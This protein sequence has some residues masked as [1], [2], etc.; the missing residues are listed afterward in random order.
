MVAGVLAEKQARGGILGGYGACMVVLLAAYYAFPPGR[1]ETWGLLCLGGV[2]GILAGLWRYRP[3]RK[4]PWLLLAA[5]LASFGAGQLSFLV[6]AQ[7]HAVLPFPSFADA[8]YLACYPLAA[9]GL[10]GF[11]SARSPHG[12]RRALI[13]GLTLTVA[14]GLLFWTFLIEPYVHDPSLSL[15]QR[16][17]TVAYP[18]G[19]VLV[20]ALLARLLAPGT[21]RSP[22]V[23]LLAVGGVA[24]MA[25]DCV[26]GWVQLSH[27]FENGGPTDLGWALFYSAWG[28]AA[29]HPTMSSLTRPVRGQQA[30]L[31]RARL[32]V[33]LLAA[34]IAPLVMLT[35][36]RRG[37]FSDVTVTAFFS[38]A[39]YMLVLARLWDSAASNQR[40][41]DRERVLRQAGLALDTA[42]DAPQIG[43]AVKNAAS[44]LLGWHA[45]GDALLGVWEDGRL[46]PVGSRADAPDLGT[47]TEAWPQ[48]T[49]GRRSAL[50]CTSA[51]PGR[52]RDIRPDAEWVLLC[53]LNLDAPGGEQIGL[54]A[55]FG[56][57]RVLADL[58]AT[59]E[60]L[61]HQAALTLQRF[62][63][64]QRGEAYFRDV[65]QDASDA[66][67]IIEDNGA[68]KYAT[69][70]T[71]SIFGAVPGRGSLFWDLV[72]EQDRAE[73]AF[74][75]SRLR[76]TA[77]TRT[78][79]QR[80]TLPD[81]RSVFI[82][83]R[84]S[85]LRANPSVAGLVLTVRDVTEQHELE[86][87]L[88]RRAFHDALTG[89]PNRVLLQD[90]IEQQA[91]AAVRT[92]AIAGVLLVDLDD[93]KIV[94]DTK[95][96]AAGDALLVAIAAR[97]SDHVRGSDTAARLGGDEF[98]VLI[99]NATD[100]LSVEA[101]A[102]RL[103]NAF[104]EPFRLPDG[105]MV[106]T[107]ITVGVA[108]TLDGSDT[109]ELL[110]HAD[111]ALYAAK[112]A[113]KRQWRR[114]QP[115]LS[116]DLD[117]EREL[118]QDLEE[119]AGKSE[120]TLAYQPIA[121]LVSGELTG[122][123]ALLR[124]PH[125]R[126]G[127]LLP[128]QFITLAEETGH[129]VPIG[130]WVLGQA[131]RDLAG[132]RRSGAGS[133]GHSLYVS[134]NVS[135]RQLEDPGFASTVRR[136]LDESGLAPSDLVLELTESAVMRNGDPLL[137]DLAGLRALG[138]RLAI[139]DFGTGYS[140]LSYLRYLPVDLIKI[141]KSF[142][143]GLGSDTRQLAL[144]TGIV[145]LAASLGFQVI[146][147]GIET[148]PQRDL[149]ASM[150]CHFGQGY[151]LARPMLPA[152]AG[153]LIQAGTNRL[154][155][156]S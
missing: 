38:A 84:L 49:P 71:A 113:G 52:A 79:N 139:D 50:A 122:F 146:A 119:A 106:K 56:E 141:D 24:V 101:A 7:V 155:F 108:T 40:A 16:A 129:I 153:E 149:L 148:G 33:L 46:R 105:T 31:S 26:Y 21:D 10:L 60:I 65:V 136:T 116:A 134:V 150:G 12:D 17:V 30:A 74:T 96:H 90:R 137:A 114:Y 86:Q 75:F 3:A 98:A 81:G 143:A 110:R 4:L 147:E 48:P 145:Q 133:R 125:S 69:P 68:V 32:V 61:A 70:S 91:A 27:P 59:L 99:S 142:I 104:T 152:S 112:A 132:W 47:L 117:R 67:V 123:E 53:P 88:K 58:A 6:A 111:L 11:V 144:V 35:A 100:E 18:L 154:A 22:C 77:G 151:L 118:K 51:L 55:V 34:L 89:L 39:L 80:I 94:N 72:A 83:A 156:D 76:E 127:M 54:I 130:A 82:Q 85:D 126:R 120:L 66:I 25:A 9:G 73:F 29:L 102:G 115:L 19:D 44:A 78:L 57:Q 14:L 63:L 43:N 36:A 45:R 1:P 62:L 103:V 124:W 138:V 140:S 128:G 92:G 95:G 20:L 107:S 97:L 131:A 109:G 64:R 15:V 37:P 28:A 5:A 135:V 87:E 23:L 8:F 121:D 41:L 13:D 42:P 93:F 2:S